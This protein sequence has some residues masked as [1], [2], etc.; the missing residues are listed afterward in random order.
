MKQINTIDVS[1][2]QIVLQVVRESKRAQGT[3]NA[4]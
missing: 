2:V 4:I 1:K 3:E